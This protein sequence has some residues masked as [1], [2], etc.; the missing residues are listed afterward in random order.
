[1]AIC[2]H[3]EATPLTP[4]PADFVAVCNDCI[5]VG[6]HWVHLRRCL[7]CEKVAC[8]DGSPAR[9]ARA[10]SGASGHPVVTSAEPDEHW[11]WCYFDEVGVG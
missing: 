8:C 10:H 7:S 5:E 3:L 11:R 4:V 1:M 9:H 2:A 6:G